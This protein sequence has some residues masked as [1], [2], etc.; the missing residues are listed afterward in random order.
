[1][2]MYR[3]GLILISMVLLFTGLLGCSNSE[4]ENGVT[5]PDYV[6][7]LAEK[8]LEAFSDGNYG[9]YLENFD[10]NAN[11]ALSE[12][13]FGQ[14]VAFV[15]ERIGY[16]ESMS[17][18]LKE[19]KPAENYTDVIYKT[20]FS[21]EPADVFVTVAYYMVDDQIYAEGIWFNSPKLFDR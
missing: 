11:R 8:L 16:Y 1:M 9:A 15:Q 19:V 17:K 21:D 13:W 14:Q 12:D 7:T 3:I 6:D 2:G 4:Q 5:V 18:E 10:I 20:K